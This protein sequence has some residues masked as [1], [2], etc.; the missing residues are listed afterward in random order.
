VYSSGY[1]PD[2]SA[3]CKSCSFRLVP[4][5]TFVSPCHTLHNNA[6]LLRVADVQSC[7]H[8]YTVGIAYSVS[9]GLL[10]QV[11]GQAKPRQVRVDVF[12]RGS[13]LMNELMQLL[14]QRVAEVGLL[15]TLVLHA[16]LMSVL[17][18]TIS[19]NQLEGLIEQCL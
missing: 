2:V 7:L 11:E 17:H 1:P 4:Q 9:E 13:V 5:Q 18:R 12:P 19:T 16:A 15:R 8:A 14:M 6:I 3:P 10:T